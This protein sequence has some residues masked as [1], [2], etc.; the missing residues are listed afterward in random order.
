MGFSGLLE[1]YKKRYQIQVVPL[2]LMTELS[3]S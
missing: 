2:R 3:D 1:D